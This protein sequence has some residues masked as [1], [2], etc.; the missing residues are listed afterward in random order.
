M[1]IMMQDRASGVTA[2]QATMPMFV[3]F[4]GSTCGKAMSGAGEHWR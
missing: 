1:L 4:Y 2:V 3:C